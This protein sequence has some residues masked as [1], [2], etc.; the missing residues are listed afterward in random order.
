MLAALKKSRLG[1]A[2]YHITK[3]PVL[4]LLPRLILSVIKHERLNPA[5]LS[6]ANRAHNARQSDILRAFDAQNTSG[7]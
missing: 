4:G 6:A 7:K 1:M 3:R 5:H 2:L